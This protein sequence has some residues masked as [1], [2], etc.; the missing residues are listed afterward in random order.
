MKKKKFS[1]TSK[2]IIII[3]TILC[4]GLIALVASSTFSLEPVRQGTGRVISPF[5]NGINDVGAWLTAQ[6]AGFNNAQ[7]LTEEN[8]QLN[9]KIDR[10]SSE[11]NILLQEKDELD[12]LRK[13][14]SLDKSYSEYEKVAAQIISKD[15]GNWYNVFTINR[16]RADGIEVDHNVIAVGGL[17]GIVTEVGENWASV[18]S[19]IDDSSNV[20]GMAATSSIHCIITGNLLLMNEGK[21]NF[22]QMMDEED[23]VTTGERIITSDISDKFLKGILIGHIS[24]I[25]YDSNTLTKTGTIIPAVDFTN[26]QEVLVITEL[27]QKGK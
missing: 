7:K 23:K 22:I 18:R 4:V 26:L 24:E 19:V 9:E 10:L 12:R 25:D 20:S 8:N 17:V 21:L 14:Y 11:N 6:T 16:G 3:M 2:H 1:I 27:K 13:L 5:Q 15:P